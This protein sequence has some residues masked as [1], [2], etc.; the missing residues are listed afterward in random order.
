MEIKEY[1]TEKEYQDLMK[2]RNKKVVKKNYRF[3][4]QTMYELAAIKENTGETE[5]EI[6]QKAINHIYWDIDR[7][8]L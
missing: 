2:K 4:A 6:I 3:S 5:T 8:P 1:L 7:S